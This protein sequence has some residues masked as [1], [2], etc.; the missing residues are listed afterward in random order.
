ML[1]SSQ[2]NSLSSKGHRFSKYSAALTLKVVCWCS[3]MIP[4]HNS[5]LT[6]CL[7]KNPTT[8]L[9]LFT[10]LS[11]LVQ[12]TVDSPPTFKHFW[13]DKLSK[14]IFLATVAVKHRSEA[15]L[16]GSFCDFKYDVKLANYFRLHQQQ[17]LNSTNICML[18]LTT[19]WSQNM[20]YECSPFFRLV[21]LSNQQIVN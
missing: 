18:K 1:K 2:D 13:L 19:A 12:S 5:L 3:E 20:Q 9:L 7:V 4:S 8:N 21:D 11:A 16:C 15:P 10:W 6:V 17:S 14:H